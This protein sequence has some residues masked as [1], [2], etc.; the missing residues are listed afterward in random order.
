L[1]I[2]F[3]INRILIPVN[4]NKILLNKVCNGYFSAIE[5]HFID[6]TD[7]ICNIPQN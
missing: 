1:L 5:F 3:L 6:V 7:I 2:L 4:D